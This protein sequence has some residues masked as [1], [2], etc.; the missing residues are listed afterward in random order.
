M[1]NKWKEFNDRVLLHITG[2]ILVFLTV[3]LIITHFEIHDNWIWF[4][5]GASFLVSISKEAYD[6]ISEDGSGFDYHTL[7]K[8]IAIPT[9]WLFTYYIKYM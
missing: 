9:I 4:S 7:V 8:E 2:V 6:E 5:Y 1:K 3:R